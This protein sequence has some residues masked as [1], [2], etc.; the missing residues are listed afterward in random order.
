MGAALLSLAGCTVDEFSE[1]DGQ[2]P[3]RLSVSQEATV[4]RAADGLYTASTGF[5]GSENVEVYVNS[6]DKHATFTVGTPDATT[7]QSSLTGTLYYPTLNDVN[8][9]AVYPSASTSS[10]TVKYDQTSADN[11]KLSDLM[12]AKKTVTQDDKEDTQNLE[13]SH[14]LVKLKVIIKKAADV[15]QVTQVKMVNVKRTVS[16]TPGTS[17]M[18]VGTATAT[19]SGNADYYSSDNNSILISGSES[20]STSAQT[21]TYA[22]VFPAQS[23]SGNDFIEVTADGKAL[24]CQLTRS[25][26]TAGAEYTLTIN[27][28]AAALGTTVSITDWDDTKPEAEVN[29]TVVKIY[30]GALSGKFRIN[31]RGDQI[32]F[33]QGNLQAIYAGSTWTWSFAQNQWDYIGNAASNNAVNGNGTVSNNGTVDLFGWST[34]A[35]LKGI[36]NSTSNATYSGDFDDWGALSITN[37]GGTANNGWRTLSSAEWAY[38]FNTRPSGST[39]NGTGN[40]RY[41]HATIRT[42][43]DGGVNGMILFPDGIRIENNEVTSWGNINSTSV[44]TGCTKCTSSEWSALAA[45]GC[46]FLPAAGYRDGTTMYN[47]GTY[48]RYWSSSPSGTEYAYGVDFLSGSLGPEDGNY[49]YRGFS[50]RLVRP[51]E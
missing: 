27:V 7:H 34:S 18:T 50:V 9:F 13:F 19:P 37:G 15:S 32:Y 1:H 8:L 6:S 43:V 4:T 42:D 38:V 20:S 39:V 5:S 47:V 17:S 16:V 44:W 22:C 49:R 35:T 11:Y 30:P 28:N 51:A 46:V 25:E 14:Q 21:Y 12:Y 40:A 45:K 10:H 31:S 3:V 48:G 29:P 36:N 23:W 24:A 41:A 26:W 33:S 2:I